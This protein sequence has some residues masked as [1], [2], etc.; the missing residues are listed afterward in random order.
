MESSFLSDGAVTFKSSTATK[1]EEEEEEKA[2]R[3]AKTA[4]AGDARLDLVFGDLPRQH[5]A[6]RDPDRRREE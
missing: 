6:D 2:E 5:G 1:R 4:N 3:N